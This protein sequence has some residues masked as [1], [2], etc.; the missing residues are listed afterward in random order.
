M[1]RVEG[2]AG[3]RQA[4]ADLRQPVAVGGEHQHLDVAGARRP[5]FGHQL[6]AVGQVRCHDDQR[7]RRGHGYVGAGERGQAGP[8]GGAGAAGRDVAAGQQQLRARRQGL[9]PGRQL[10]GPRQ[11]G[12]L[13]QRGAS[14]MQRAVYRA[15]QQMQRADVGA[16]AQQ[17]G[18]PGDAVVCGVQRHDLQRLPGLPPRLQLGQPAVGRGQQAVD[19]RD[20]GPRR[21]LQRRGLQRGRIQPPLV[22]ESPYAD[23]TAR[24]GCGEVR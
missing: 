15:A 3:L 21:R 14:E 18:G 13:V 10:A 8:Q 4:L 2:A 5:Q 7:A 22:E 11:Q 20:L 1:H 19:E 6:R 23:R 12:R 17:L 24:E 16:A 9:A